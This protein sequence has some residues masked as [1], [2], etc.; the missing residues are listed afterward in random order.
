MKKSIEKTEKAERIILKQYIFYDGVKSGIQIYNH[1]DYYKMIGY[2][3]RAS[4]IH[5]FKQ[6]LRNLVAKNPPCMQWIQVCSLVRELRSP[7]PQSN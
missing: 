5:L 7:M 1:S 4:F 3:L 2:I 6:I